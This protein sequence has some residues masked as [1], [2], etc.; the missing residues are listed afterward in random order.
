[1]SDMID[2][3]TPLQGMDSASVQSGPC[4]L[5]HRGNQ[6]ALQRYG[7]PKHGNGR[8]DPGAKRLWRE[9]KS[10]SDYGRGIEE[11]AQYRRLNR[12]WEE[13]LLP[14]GS[15]QAMK[16]CQAHCT[17]PGWRR[18]RERHDSSGPHSETLGFGTEM[19]LGRSAPGLA[20]C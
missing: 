4:R 11:L 10:G 16:S 2:F 3:Q 1:M 17:R 13:Q 15:F 8:P 19:S 9:R 20:G 12:I 18:R 7:G 6:P 14:A 5:A